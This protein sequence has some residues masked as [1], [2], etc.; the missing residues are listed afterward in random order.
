MTERSRPSFSCIMPT[1]NRSD[2]VE[3]T[4]RQLLACDYPDD[5][6]EIIVADNS[7]DDT[8]DM[9][10]RVGRDSRVPVRLIRSSERL[11]AVKRNEALR[12]ATG[13]YVVFMNDDLWVRPDFL[14]EHERAHER[15]PGP[16]A[17]LGHVEQSPKMPQDPFIEWYTPFAYQELTDRVDEPLEWL[18][19]WT[20]NLS[21]SREEM[22]QRNLVFHEDWAEIGSEDVELGY[23]WTSAG[24]ELVYH[25]EAWGEHYHPH[26]LD[27]A[28]R[29]QET[30]G[31]GL[32]DLEV[33]VPEPALLERYGIF[34]WRNHPKA[35][36][37]GLA[38]MTLFNRYTVPPVQRRLGRVRRSSALSRWTYWKVLSFYTNRGYR[39]APP[40]HPAA[41]ETR[42]RRK[43]P[44]S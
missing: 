22:L 40:R 39:Q 5:R 7:S 43:E 20:M 26:S 24:N 23:R 2:V 19:F 4:I 6:Y 41:L 21:L 37:R 33:L 16:V 31:R 17:V 38:R 25:P 8:P 42:P 35:I 13:D 32:R 10:E 1:Y 29:L 28:S 34:S 3:Q 15:H 30:V 9:V 18:Y 11:P 27:S 36:A 14:V 12:A 44:V